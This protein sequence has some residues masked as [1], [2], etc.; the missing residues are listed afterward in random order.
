MSTLVERSN[1]SM[2]VDR[3]VEVAY[4]LV[5]GFFHQVNPTAESRN[6]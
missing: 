4:R 3:N 6:N 1:R 2:T 5:E